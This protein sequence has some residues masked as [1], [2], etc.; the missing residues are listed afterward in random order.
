M[1]SNKWIPLCWV[2]VFNDEELFADVF[3]NFIE[4]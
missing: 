4:L 2:E 1:K 3:E